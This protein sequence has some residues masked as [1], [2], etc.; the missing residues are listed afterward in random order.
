MLDEGYAQGGLILRDLDFYEK[1]GLQETWAILIA[2][3]IIGFPHDEV[4]PKAVKPRKP[5]SERQQIVTRKT[6]WP[7]RTFQNRGDK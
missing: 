1:R 3:G 5:K 4:K 7:K 6:T 2:D